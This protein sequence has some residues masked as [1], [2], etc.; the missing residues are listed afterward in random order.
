[1][2]TMSNTYKVLIVDDEEDLCEIL[3]FN[4]QG[5]GIDTELAYSAESALQKDLAAFDLLLLDVMMERMSGF[6]LADII[7]KEMGLDIPIIFITAKNTENDLLTGFNLGAD[8]FITKPFSIKEVIARVKAVLS[9]IPHQGSASSKSIR[10]EGLELNFERRVLI[11]GQDEVDLTKKEF[12]ILSLLLEKPGRIFSR[13]EILL[14]AWD[15]DTIV[16]DRTIDVH[17]TRL[18]KK[19]EKSGFR[20]KNKPGYGYTFLDK[21]Q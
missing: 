7:R 6:K 15:D 20:I 3:Q 9:R 18:R 12:E 5:E 21:N 10:L 17:I 1:M 16:T 19:I 11:L 13:E 2:N 14:R 4:L 8:D